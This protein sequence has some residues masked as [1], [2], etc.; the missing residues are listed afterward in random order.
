MAQ[1]GLALSLLQELG[2][3]SAVYAPPKHLVPP[4]PEGGFDWARGAAVA[5]AAA[6]LL[7]LRSNV[8]EVGQ[9]STQMRDET[10]DRGGSCTGGNEKEAPRTLVREL[11]LCAALLPLTGVK[12]QAKKGKLVSASQ[13][14]V[15]DSLKVLVF[16]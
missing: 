15:S 5:R 3:A 2:L 8:V 13:S 4:A 16:Q 14:V 9:P 11:F 7:A 10:A 1:P 6:R 12:H